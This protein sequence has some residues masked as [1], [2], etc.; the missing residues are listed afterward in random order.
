MNEQRIGVW[1][2]FAAMIL[3]IGADAIVSWSRDKAE[4]FQFDELETA[5]F[6]P[7]PEYVQDSVVG[8]ERTA[9]SEWVKKN[10]GKP[11][12]MITGVKIARGAQHLRSRMR[13][14][15]FEFKP[16]VDATPFVGVPVS[17]GP[18]VGAAR[19][20]GDATWFSN[21][22]D[23]VFAYRLRRIIIKRQL[24]TKEK[25]YVKG[26]V[27]LHQGHE[28]DDSTTHGIPVPRKIENDDDMLIQSV[29]HSRND[30]GSSGYHLDGFHS[31][32]VRDEHDD[33]DCLLQIPEEMV[34]F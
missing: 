8:P 4:V 26:A 23:F 10:R 30:Y 22:S 3:G 2:Q 21:S 33:E 19:T 13:G 28:K 6:N 5:F 12:Y 29:D 15:D 9:V 27:V 11:V 14:V 32:E 24:V 17:G 18:L 31:V 7:G 25:D 16:G 20:K 34:H 1:A